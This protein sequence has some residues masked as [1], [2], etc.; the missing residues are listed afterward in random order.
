MAR[1]IQSILTREGLVH[2]TGGT[3][4]DARSSFW[5]DRYAEGVQFNG[6]LPLFYLI[7]G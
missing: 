3:G 1:R 2:R 6:T 7:H 5:H 4:K